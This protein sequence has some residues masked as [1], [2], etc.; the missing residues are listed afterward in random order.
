MFNLAVRGHDLSGITRP[1]SLAQA[2]A[3]KDVRNVQFALS[4][5]FP[6]WSAADKINPGMGTF[7]KQ[8]FAASHVQIALLSCYSNLIHP[9]AAVREE[10]LSKFEQYLF[11]ARYFGAA[12]VASETGSVIPALGYSE[13][14]FTDAVFD[15][16]VEVISRLV[17]V[18]EQHQTMVGI[19]AGLNHPL[20]SNHRIAELIKRVPSPYLGIIYDPTNLITAE[21]AADQVSIVKEAFEMFGDQ[22]VCLHLKDYQIDGNRIV[23]VP[24]GEGQIAYKEILNILQEKKPMCYVVLEETKDTGIERAVTLLKNL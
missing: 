19:E 18:G 7:F 1:E 3:S 14:N 2:V 13:E 24:L 20:Y 4:A 6:E 5:S 15:D 22:I 8:T 16:L 21:T 9:D 11:H 10:I 23:P 17:S 12:M